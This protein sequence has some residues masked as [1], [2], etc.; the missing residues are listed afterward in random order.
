MFLGASAMSISIKL[1]ESNGQIADKIYQAAAD[2]INKKIQ[3]NHKRAVRG[4][5]ELIPVWIKSQPEIVSL[6][7]EGDSTSLNSQFGLVP[8]QGNAVLNEIINAVKAST[9]INIH[10][11]NKS[12][13][14]GLTIEIQPVDYNNIISLS[15][16][17]I[18]YPI[19]SLNFL[20]WLLLKGD[21]V[22]IVGHK[23]KIG[24]T[25]RSGHGIMIS[26][27]SWRVPPE[28]SGSV[29]NN[30]ITRAF[31]GREKELT[32]LLQQVIA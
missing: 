19:A 21:T 5:Q 15:E 23:Y 25:G 3:K 29:D 11:V 17:L 7:A 27:G 1:L 4:L 18:K 24:T 20:D 22:I 31:S 8:G 14:G 16:G 12:L 32:H 9:A 28:F 2:L 13:Q 30:F 26:G 6:L 10:K